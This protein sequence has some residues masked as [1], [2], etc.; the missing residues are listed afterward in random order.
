MK[1]CNCKNKRKTGLCCH[2]R[3]LAISDQNRLRILE[4]LSEKELCVCEIYEKLNLAQNLVSHHLKVLSDSGLVSFRKVG[5][6]VYYKLNK[7]AVD[8]L[9][10]LLE[11]LN[12]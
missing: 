1:K 3:F 4:L 8:D 5:K 2:G 10:K 12:R 9:N 6:N 11:S 7:K